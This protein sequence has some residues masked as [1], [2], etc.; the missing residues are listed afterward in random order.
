MTT[1]AGSG[2][3]VLSGTYVPAWARGGR[4]RAKDSWGEEDGG[5]GKRPR[6][7]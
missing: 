4:P 5:G 1:G 2:G 7:E 6:A 3:Y